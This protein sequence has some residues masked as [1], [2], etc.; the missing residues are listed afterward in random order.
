MSLSIMVKKYNL[1]SQ[2][3]HLKFKKHAASSESAKPTPTLRPSCCCPHS[4]P[5]AAGPTVSRTA[6]RLPHCPAASWAL[7]PTAHQ[8]GL[9]SLTLSPSWHHAR[10]ARFTPAS[11]PWPQRAPGDQPS[12]EPTLALPKTPSGVTGSLQCAPVQAEASRAHRACEGR[13]VAH[14]AST[15]KAQSTPKKRNPCGSRPLIAQA[16]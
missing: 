12:Q 13:P 8:A 14:T 5:Q 6:R 3:Y 9:T 2:V 16:C 10:S 4:R 15:T 1:E 7:E 11:P